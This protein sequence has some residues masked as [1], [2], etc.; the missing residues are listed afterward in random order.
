MALN[1]PVEPVGS[2]S[3]G[4]REPRSATCQLLAAVSI[5]YPT[6][7]TRCFSHSFQYY[8]DAKRRTLI[9]V[10]TNQ[11][12]SIISRI[13]DCNAQTRPRQNGRLLAAGFRLDAASLVFQRS[14]SRAVGQWRSRSKTNSVTRPICHKRP[15]S[16]AVWP[17]RLLGTALRLSA[18]S[19]R[20]L[21]LREDDAS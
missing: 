21:A 9:I 18:L 15:Q 17:R 12:L 1:R 16:C 11:P 3:R 4:C 14:A 5:Q 19:L 10:W 13:R 8:T 20:L 2:K 6:I 7:S